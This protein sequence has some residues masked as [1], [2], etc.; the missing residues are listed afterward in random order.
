M[1]MKLATGQFLEGIDAAI[2]EAFH[3]K[4]FWLKFNGTFVS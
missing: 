1:S 3:I 4:L 2:L